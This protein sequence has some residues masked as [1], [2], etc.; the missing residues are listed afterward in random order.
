MAKYFNHLGYNKDLKEI[1]RKL[2]NDSTPAEIRLWV[3][4]LR[5]KQMKGYQ[6]LRQRPVLNY[7][8]DFMYKELRLII[9]VDGGSHEYEHQWYKDELRQKELENMGLPY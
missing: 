4:L 3:K 8:A 1:A 9:E 6:F 2:R 7:I 5:A